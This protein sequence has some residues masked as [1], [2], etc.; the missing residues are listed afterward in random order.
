MNSSTQNPLLELHKLGVSAWLD[1]ISRDRL[2]TG[3]LQDLVEHQHVVGVTSNPTIFQK[4]M[5]KG[6][7]YDEQIRDLARRGVALE[8][9]VRLMT[10]YDIRWACDVFLP[11]YEASNHVDGRVSIE[12]DPRIA[13]DEART[14]AEATGLRWLV[15]PRRGGTDCVWLPPTTRNPSGRCTV[16]VSPGSGVVTSAVKVN[17]PPGTKSPPALKPSRPELETMPVP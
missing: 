3:N 15:P 17:V 2:R 16:S 14:T 13:H 9:A 10:S 7:A 4:A 6:D 8:E 12:V 11:T 5:E 1:D